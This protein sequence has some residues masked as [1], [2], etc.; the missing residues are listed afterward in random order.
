[1]QSLSKLSL[2]KIAQLSVLSLVSAL[3]ACGGGGGNGGGQDSSNN[4]GASRSVAVKGTVSKGV[5]RNG[6]VSI[7]AI[8]AGTSGRLLA[9]TTTNQNGQFTATVSGYD[10]PVYIEV[11]ASTGSTPTTMLCDAA[12]GCGTF[13]A[14]IQ[15]DTNQNLVIDFGESFQVSSDFLLTTALP[16]G[17]LG[18]LTSVSTLTHLAAQFAA[19]MPQGFNDVSIA[20]AM[21]QVQN[22]FGLGSSLIGLKAIDLT[23]PTAVSNASSSELR[24]ALLSSAI[25]GLTNDIAFSSTL[26]ALTH[27]FLSNNGQL[28]QRGNDMLVPSFLDLAQ[29]ALATAQQLNL[30]TFTSEFQQLVAALQAADLNSVTNSQASPGAGGATAAKVAAFVQDLQLWQGYL[31]LNPNQSSFAQMV[32]SMGVATGADM[33]HMLQALAIAGQYGPIVALPDL[34]LGA[35]CDSLG[36][37]LA[38]LTCR[39]L[40]AGKSLQEICEGA[41]HLVIFGRSLCDILNDLTL[42]L[43]AGVYGHFALY[44]GVVRIY[45]SIEDADVNLT[46]TRNTRSSN[47]YG[48]RVTGTVDTDTGSMLIESGSVSM[49]FNGG[50]DIRNLKLP[51]TASGSIQI[52]YAQQGTVENPAGMEF[53]GSVTLD[54]DLRNVRSTETQ[55][56]YAG[57]DQIQLALTANGEFSSGQGQSFAGSLSINGGI[58]SNVIVRF[59]TDLPDY[60]DRAMIQLTATPAQMANGLVSDIRMTWGGKQYDILNFTGDNSGIRITNQDGIIMDLDLTVEDGHTAGYLQLN[61]VR[62]GTVSPLNGSLLFTLADGSETVL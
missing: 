37:Y 23:N 14:G 18:T 50:L 25:M 51:E 19:Q 42:P 55:G 60:S 45:G 56:S 40:I 16:S 46:F 57:L 5:I 15:Y 34:A 21:S 6:V 26:Q 31:S 33:T 59:E 4:N 52:H 2:K 1:M 35:A 32:S 54:L 43:G 11:T 53:D 17:S 7:Y 3:A 48:F 9:S 41:L 30:V 22:L 27:S 44:D 61:G 49:V 20:V 36:N 28:I 12:A 29:Q 62:F 39:I 38:R 13:A 10:G 8:E 24:Y 47:R 58:N